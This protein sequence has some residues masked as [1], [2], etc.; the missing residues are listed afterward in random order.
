MTLTQKKIDELESNV[1][2]IITNDNLKPFTQS[3]ILEKY[4]YE[5]WNLYQLDRKERHIIN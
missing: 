3:I 5:L 1:S 4:H 2:E